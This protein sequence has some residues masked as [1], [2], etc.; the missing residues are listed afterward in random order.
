[1][2]Q[3]T[4]PTAT[5]NE[6]PGVQVACQ[7]A[8]GSV[9]PVGVTTVTCA[10]LDAQGNRGEATFRVTVTG[11]PA[12]PS[13]PGTAPPS[14]EAPATALGLGRRLL[15]VPAG[16]RRLEVPCALDRPVLRRCA[17]TLAA[18]G[19]TLARGTADAAAGASSATVAL[20]L[21]AATVR[22]A[23]RAG[24]LA[25]TLQ[26]TAEQTG[27]GAPLRVRVGVL[28]LPSPVVT[29]AA[30]ALFRGGATTLPARGTA[31]LRSL[32]DL[33]AGARRVTCTGH[34]DDRGAAAANRRLGLARA[35]SVCA[36]LT[37]GSGLAG[38]AAGRGESAPRGSNRT[39]AGRAA[40]RR[41]TVAVEY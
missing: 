14:A 32:R 4:P 40:N 39:A 10:A 38:R 17:L 3:F 19:K 9:F 23:R 15:V 11:P 5:D 30:D 28:L 8:S 34:T 6:T 33:L 22:L 29:L 36:F 12:P 7:P 16:A 41:V 26:A 13:D 20:T 35:R 37:H 27:P 25:A 21:D 18:G 24:G 2:V 31:S 1:M